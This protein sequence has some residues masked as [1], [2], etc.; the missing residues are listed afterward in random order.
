MEGEQGR[1]PRWKERWSD[2]AGQ[3]DKRSERLPTQPNPIPS[4]EQ[5]PGWEC[6]R[7]TAAAHFIYTVRPSVLLWRRERWIYTAQNSE[8]SNQ[9]ETKKNIQPLT[10][11]LQENSS[12]IQN[13]VQ[14]QEKIAG[15]SKSKD[16]LRNKEAAQRRDD[17][18]LKH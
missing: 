1:N 18:N 4:E 3:K 9:F 13:P 2:K 10:K 12:F 6:Y 5:P 14:M 15:K 11:Q 17:L 7:C 16:T 8:S